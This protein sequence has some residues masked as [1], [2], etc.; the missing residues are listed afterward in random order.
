[1][2]EADL[3]AVP[4]VWPEPFGLVGIEAG[5]VGLP[6]VA[7]AVG[8]IPD[9]LIPG[10]SGELAPGDPPTADGLALAIVRALADPTPLQRLRIGAW[11]VAR[12]FR[13]GRHLDEL[14]RILDAAHPAA[15]GGALMLKALLRRAA[16][17]WLWSRL[18][19]W[20]MRRML[21]NFT[22]YTAEHTYAGVRLKVRIADTLAQGWYDHDWGPLPEIDLLRQGALHPGARVLDL[23]AHQGVV[24]MILAH[25]VGPSGQVVA[26]EALPHNAR[27]AEVNRDLNGFGQIRVEAAA[28][29]DQPGE[30]EISTG[31]N[32][33]VRNAATDIGTTRVPAVTVDG[34]AERHGPPDV[35]FIDVEGYECHALRGAGR[36]LERRP[37]CYVEVHGGCGL[38][39]AGGSV[40]DVF[41]L[42]PASGYELLAWTEA[43]PMPAVVAGPAD[44]P[45][46][47]FFL[48]A[49]RRG[50]LAGNGES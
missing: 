11:E 24:A 10:K 39:R 48:V 16:P 47:R 28:V 49:R 25:H 27:M 17:R 35:L 1:M 2:R 4:S 13:P 3:L 50:R 22:P 21:A 36:T 46:G 45:Q 8:G 33:Q 14:E 18:R 20:K 15:E 44:C 31:L 38:E 42:L 5:C 34:L 37:E 12:T 19:T 26:V 43:R 41:R 40:A 32:G 30:L 29:S 6:A 7:F 9:W 23:G